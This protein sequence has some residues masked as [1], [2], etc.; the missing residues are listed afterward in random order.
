MVPV[1]PVGMIAPIA[2]HVN[3][4]GAFPA[5]VVICA[6]DPIGPHPDRLLLVP[7]RSSIFVVS[8]FSKQARN[9]SFFSARSDFRP[10]FHGP[11]NRKTLIYQ[12]KLSFLARF[13]LFVKQK[14]S[15]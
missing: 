5:P 14:F 15:E 8:Q 12:Q 11:L 6:A 3:K 2:G 4:K 1:A 7:I 9:D 10:D 13:Q